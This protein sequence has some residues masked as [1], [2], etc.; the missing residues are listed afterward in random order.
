MDTLAIMA[1]ESKKY[2]ILYAIKITDTTEYYVRLDPG[3]FAMRSESYTTR[4]KTRMK[5]KGV[6]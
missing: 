6:E 4:P 2:K 5:C 3:T 1:N